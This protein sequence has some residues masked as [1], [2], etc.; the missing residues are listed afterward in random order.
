LTRYLRKTLS[1]ATVKHARQVRAGANADRYEGE[2]PCL[3][4]ELGMTAEDFSQWMT[5]ALLPRPAGA[6]ISNRGAASVSK[7]H[8]GGLPNSLRDMLAH[9]IETPSTSIR[10]M[11][12]MY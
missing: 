2:L 5:N 9:G 8:S 4:G 7:S 12:S 3:M 1:K 6:D 11:K 10:D